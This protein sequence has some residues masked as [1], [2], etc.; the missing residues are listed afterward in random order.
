MILECFV[1]HHYTRKLFQETLYQTKELHQET[2]ETPLV[3]I[4]DA[5][6]PKQAWLLKGYS[7]DTRDPKHK[8]FNTKLCSARVVTGNACGMKEDLEFCIKNPSAG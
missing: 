3:T 7:E 4:G 6:F 2:L 5:S 8:Y 1:V